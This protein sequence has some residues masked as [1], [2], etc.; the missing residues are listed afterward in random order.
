MYWNIILL[1][2]TKILPITTAPVLK[3]SD[4]LPIETLITVFND[5]YSLYLKNILINFYVYFLYYILYSSVLY[6]GWILI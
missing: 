5:M 4:I 6:I 2:T 3:Y 1:S